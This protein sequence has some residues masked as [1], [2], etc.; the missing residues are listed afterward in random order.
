MPVKVAEEGGQGRR[1]RGVKVVEEGVK[2]IE[3]GGSMSLDT[4][5]SSQT[6]TTTTTTPHEL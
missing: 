1:G 4:S 6:T 3:E 5:K 2:V